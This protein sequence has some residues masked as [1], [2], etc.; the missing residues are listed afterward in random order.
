M[1]LFASTSEAGFVAASGSL[2]IAGLAVPL[3]VVRR[4]IRVA[5]AGA[6]LAITLSR[7]R[8][9]QALAALRRRRPV[10]VRLTVVATDR[11]GNSRQARALTVRL[12]R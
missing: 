10:T 9:R 3:K 11:A 8:W 4:Q 7:A 6:E 2:S 1:R 12:R 5:G